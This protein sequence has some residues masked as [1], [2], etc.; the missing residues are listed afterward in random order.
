MKKSIVWTLLFSIILGITASLPA[1][2]AVIRGDVDGDGNIT[3]ADARQI[4]R[5]AVNLE[6]PLSAVRPNADVDEDGGITASDARL[7]LRLAVGLETAFTLALYSTAHA[8]NGKDSEYFS[9]KVSSLSIDRIYF[10]VNKW[11]CYYTIHEVFRPA[12]EKAGY[13]KERINQ[14][15]PNIYE[16]DRMAK[17][18]KNT[19]NST[20]APWQM[21]LIRS[22]YV[23]SLLA[24]YYLTHPDYAACFTF[25]PY[26]DDILENKLY[27]PT[28][29]LSAYVPEIGDVLF[30]SNK[31]AT[32]VDGIPTIDHTAQIIRID[33][34]G[35]F[36]CTDGCILPT[37]EGEN[38]RVVERRYVWSDAKH[39][40]VWDGNDIVQTLLIAKPAL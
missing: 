6:A 10:V 14:L 23:P 32:Y 27:E 28:A 34:D 5:Y 9:A 15:A 8:N 21:N 25:L 30:V 38:P 35:S 18:I 20:L 36:I 17:A 1:R 39:T 16:K 33:P 40:W 24:D 7:A 11:C 19:V 12:L 22:A 37:V 31:T 3:A 2:A 26:Y 29:N 13:S 4:L